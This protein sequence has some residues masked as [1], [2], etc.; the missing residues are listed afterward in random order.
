MSHFA[1]T[2][3][4]ADIHRS[5]RK[6][7]MDLLVTR[8][9]KY[10]RFTPSSKRLDDIFEHRNMLTTALNLRG[11]AGIPFA[12]IG[13]HAINLH[14]INRITQDVDL[15]IAPRRWDA[16]ARRWATSRRSWNR[17][18][19]TGPPEASASPAMIQYIVLF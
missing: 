1:N 3:P 4:P 2:V 17:A 16:A 12:V 13:G 9:P 18:D 5:K 6:R 11:L 7:F 10:R 15:M 14:G 19:E 8:A